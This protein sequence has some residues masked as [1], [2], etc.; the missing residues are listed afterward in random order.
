MDGDR[1][2]R[3]CRCVERDGDGLLLDRSNGS[4]GSALGER[5]S[6]LGAWETLSLDGFFRRNPVCGDLTAAGVVGSASS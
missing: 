1:G 3:L 6:N 5:A 4:T 2:A